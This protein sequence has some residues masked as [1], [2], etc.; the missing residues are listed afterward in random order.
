[1]R[2]DLQGHLLSP[3]LDCPQMPLLMHVLLFS[4]VVRQVRLTTTL[5]CKRHLPAAGPEM[6]YAAKP[7]SMAG[8]SGKA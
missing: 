4:D 7:W 2:R 6:T 8:I 3:Y 5:G 1:M